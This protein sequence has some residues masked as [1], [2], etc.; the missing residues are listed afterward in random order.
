MVGDLADD[1]EA[2]KSKS[3]VGD[4]G[5]MPPLRCKPGSEVVNLL[6]SRG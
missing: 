3:V 1:T 4:P 6:P 2:G 5:E